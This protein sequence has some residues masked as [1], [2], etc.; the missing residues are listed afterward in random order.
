MVEVHPR[1]APSPLPQ[2]D[3]MWAWVWAAGTQVGAAWAGWTHWGVEPAKSRANRSG[4]TRL[5][6][7]LQ[8]RR[9]PAA[10]PRSR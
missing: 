8:K 9:G 10:A 6:A 7:L 1:C 2:A 3:G 4:S 5:A